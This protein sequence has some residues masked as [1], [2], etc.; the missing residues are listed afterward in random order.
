VNTDN[1]VFHSWA[2]T[3]PDGHFDG[4]ESILPAPDHPV[5]HGLTRNLVS[6]LLFMLSED[7]RMEVEMSLRD[8]LCAALLRRTRVYNTKTKNINGLS[9]SEWAMVLTVAPKAFS[10]VLRQPVCSP[11]SAP[12]SLLLDLLNMSR[13]WTVNL[14]YYP[15]VSLDGA[16]E[17]RARLGCDQLSI[18]LDLFMDAVVRACERLDCMLLKRALDTPNLHGMRE[19][20]LVVS[21]SGGVGHARHFSEMGLEGAHEPL[22]TAISRGNGQDD[23][24]HAIRQMQLSE[25]FSRLAFGAVVLWCPLVVDGPC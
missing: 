9:I 17:F 14:Y 13:D 11:L 6:A 5:F 24:G 22:K 23:A 4:H 2:T 19:V 8:C 15:R 21:S 20:A 12:L 25:V 18:Q 16:A 3:F 1:A 7:L 10:R